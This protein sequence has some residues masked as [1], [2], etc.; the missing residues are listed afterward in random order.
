MP[1]LDQELLVFKKSIDAGL[2]RTAAEYPCDGIPLIRDAMLYSLEGGKRLRGTVILSLFKDLAGF[3]DAMPF[4]LAMEMIQAYS[5]VHDDL[6]CM[7]DDDFR[8]GMPTCHKKYGQAV[9]VLTG[10]ALL[11][12][13]FETAASARISPEL[14]I[15][16]I[17]ALAEGAGAAGMVGGQVIDLQSK[18]GSVFQADAVRAM[19]R[20]KTGRLFETSARIGC[21]LAGAGHSETERISA[22]GSHFGYAYQILDDLDD[23]E[24]EDDK[25]TLVKIIGADAVRKE[26]VES[27]R[28]SLEC[29]RPEWLLARLSRR[30]LEGQE[31]KCLKLE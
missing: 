17:R 27:L 13:A 28:K 2:V 6:P 30:F 9:A 4:A 26:A 19:Y 18:P 25:D 12:L 3:G 24:E 29:V 22:W 20:L 10:D 8:R 31:T 21:V 7:D 5:L 14:T 15:R 1:Q 23:M 16:G 11:T